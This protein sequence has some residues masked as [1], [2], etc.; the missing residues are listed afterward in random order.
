MAYAFALPEFDG[1]LAG[2][3]FLALGGTF[4]FVPSFQMANAFP[5]YSGSIVAVITGSFDASAAVFLFYRLVYEATQHSFGPNKFFFYYIVVPALI[6][7]FEILL[8]PSQSYD[9]LPQLEEKIEKVQDASRDV[10]DSDDEIESR[11]EVRRVRR[12]RENRRLNKIR[13]LD[14]LIGD[15][16]EREQRAEREEEIKAKS[17]VW[18]VLHG[19]P[20]HVQMLSPWFILITLLTVLQMLRMNYFIATIR[21]QYEFML[22]SASDAKKINDFFDIALPLGGVI[23]TPFIGLFLDNLS[24]PLTLTVIVGLITVIGVLNSLPFV[25]AGYATVC[26]F[27]LLRPLYY[28]AMS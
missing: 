17:A 2:N 9:T 3:F 5:K 21:S 19:Q 12:R 10:H 14:D 23:C 8:L 24:I 15:E 1:Y 26:L 4:I 18:G 7:L 6:L 13:Q 25:W 27:V 28:S 22:D 20:A 16:D 11:A